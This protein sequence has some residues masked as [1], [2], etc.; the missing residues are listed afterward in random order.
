MT[1]SEI[2]LH[3]C[4]LLELK[5]TGTVVE[6]TTS[7]WEHVLR[8]LDLNSDLSIEC[9]NHQ[10]VEGLRED[11]QTAVQSR[12]LSSISRASSLARIREAKFVK[13]TTV[14]T[15]EFDDCF[16]HGV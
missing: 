11:I 7:F 14:C 9:F 8:V 6:Y 2:H 4:S 1:A 13:D 15:M 12:S 5:H 16:G 3:M 10:Y